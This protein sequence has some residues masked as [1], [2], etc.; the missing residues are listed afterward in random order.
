MSGAYD[1]RVPVTFEY[2]DGSRAKD[3]LPCDGGGHDHGDSGNNGLQEGSVPVWNGMDRFSIK[4]HKFQN[5][6]DAALFEVLIAAQPDKELVA[7]VLE[8]AGGYYR[9]R[10]TRFHLFAATG[11]RVVPR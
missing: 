7:F 1:S 4:K 10:I 6:K 2:R 11:M 5:V 3:V 8:P 9:R